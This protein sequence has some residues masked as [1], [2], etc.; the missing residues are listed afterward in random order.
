MF[1]LHNYGTI[2]SIEYFTPLAL[3]NLLF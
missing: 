1:Y 3:F 2:V